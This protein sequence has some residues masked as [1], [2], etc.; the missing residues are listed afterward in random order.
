MLALIVLMGVLGMGAAAEDALTI[1]GV[2]TNPDGTAAIAWTAEDAGPYRISYAVKYTDDAAADFGAGYGRYLLAENWAETSF[3]VERVVPGQSYWFIV[4]SERGQEAV[5][6]WQSP[7]TQPLTDC[8]LRMSASPR[9]R[10]GENVRQV[11]S[12]NAQDVAGGKAA[13]GLCINL[14]YSGLTQDRDALLV[15]NL[16]DPHGGIVTEYAAPLTLRSDGA[17]RRA[18]AF[19][20]LTWYFAQAMRAYGEIPAGTY[21]LDAYLGGKHGARTTFAVA[22]DA[23]SART[24]FVLEPNGDGSV[25]LSWPDDG[26]G[27]W[28]VRYAPRYTGDVQADLAS[29]E[30]MGV[31]AAAADAPSCT[32]TQLVPGEDYWIGVFDALGSGVYLPYTP[33]KTADFAGFDTA[34]Y[35]TPRMQQNGAL[36]D[37]GSFRRDALLAGDACGLELGL[38]FTNAQSADCLMQVIVAAP[39]GAKIVCS[40]AR[41]TFPPAENSSMGWP[42]F[43]L[44]P[45]F[46]ALQRRFGQI[47]AGEYRISIA[48]NGQSAGEGSFRVVPEDAALAL[49]DITPHENGTADIAWTDSGYGPFTVRFIPDDGPHLARE[50]AQTLDD[51]CTAT[52]LIPGQSGLIVV[53]DAAGHRSEMPFTLPEAKLGAGSIDVTPCRTESGRRYA[54]QGLWLD[55]VDPADAGLYITPKNADGQRALLTLTAPGGASVVLHEAA[56]GGPWA[57]SL[58][59]AFDRLGTAEGDYRVD[60]YLDGLH[61]G[62]GVF[63][64]AA[65]RPQTLHILSCEPDDKGGTIVNWTDALQNGPYTVRH[66]TATGDDLA[67]DWQSAW[68]IRR[69]AENLAETTV[70]LTHL[71]PGESQWIVVE[72]GD[73]NR[74][75]LRYTPPN[76]PFTAFGAQV[77][78]RLR[79]RDNTTMITT[80]RNAFSAGRTARDTIDCGLIVDLEYPMLAR[81]RTHTATF[82]LQCPTG[83]KVVDWVT[84]IELEYGNSTFGWSHYSLDWYFDLLLEQKGYIPTGTYTLLLYF[85]G[86]FVDDARFEMIG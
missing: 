25:R 76:E 86:L 24:P 57:V 40:A 63:P 31:M 30:G 75:S 38:R 45:C 79:E 78:L 55:E 34:L 50:L 22:A 71:V 52:A 36:T 12:L 10:V 32:L 15:L 35:L 68:I 37:L 18:W 1:T 48:L 74:A 9:V 77:L 64:V 73:G 7:E 70:T 72:D 62:S 82:V 60:L 84:E 65:S 42:F 28:Q 21:T 49:T 26:C 59:D 46:A 27:P 16:T 11:I 19:Y 41:V 81:N 39:G 4:G 13:Y 80:T 85:D 14:A 8:T 53:T 5:A 56:D 20:D 67:A 69:D 6:A 54:L 3:T 51:H 58:A 23:A 61:A 29:P 44:K 66:L 17:Y 2:Q 83:E 33:E 47:P 43:T